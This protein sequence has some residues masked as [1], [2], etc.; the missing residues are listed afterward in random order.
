MD[1]FANDKKIKIIM[2]AMAL[3]ILV[4]IIILAIP[5]K[6]TPTIVDTNNTEETTT[7]NTKVETNTVGTIRATTTEIK[8]KFRAEVP[9]NIVIPTQETKLTEA[10]KKEIALP[11][12]VM[13]AAPGVESSFRSFDIKAEGGVFTPNKIIARLGDTV[14]INFTAVDKDYDIMFPSY[15]MRQTAKQGQTKVLEF[16]AVS[17]GSFLYYCNK[18]G[19]E[20]STTKGNIII[21]K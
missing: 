6:N 10:E 21:A 4:L 9:K 14:H 11:T 12:V 1:N 13:P 16:Q 19:G 8:D 5:K 20:Q 17:E 7:T 2:A 15:N 18:C 3:V